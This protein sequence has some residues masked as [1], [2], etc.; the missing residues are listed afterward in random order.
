CPRS[1]T[2]RR[3]PTSTLFPYMTL[4]R[5]RNDRRC[6]RRGTMAQHTVERGP[7][8]RD[9]GHDAVPDREL[10]A[11]PHGG[12]DDLRRSRLPRRPQRGR[13]VS[14]G[15]PCRPRARAPN[16]SFFPGEE[17]E[18]TLTTMLGFPKPIVAR[19]RV[20]TSPAPA[21]FESISGQAQ[22]DGDPRHV[23]V[24][25][26]NGD[27]KLDLVVHHSYYAGVFLNPG[28]GTLG[29]VTRY[30]AGYYTNIGALGDLDGDGHLDI[31]ATRDTRDNIAVFFNNGDGTFAG[32]TFV[33]APDS[34]TS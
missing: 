17:V 15:P 5:S 1:P 11:H 20:A 29:S 6:A 4:F 24:G 12:R 27:G 30:N 33:P 16:G 32:P 13:A 28:N 8:P 34:A 9:P 3:P 31:V 25:D 23:S 26:L 21:R 22:L 10:R 19:Y 7:R 2:P 18:V 14:G